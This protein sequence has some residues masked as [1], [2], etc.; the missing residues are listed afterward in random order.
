[1]NHQDENHLSNPAAGVSRGSF[2]RRSTLSA[3]AIL[4]LS[5]GIGLATAE[6]TEI[7]EKDCSYSY[8]VEPITIYKDYPGSGEYYKIVKCYCVNGHLQGKFWIASEHSI[9]AVNA[10]RTGQQHTPGGHSLSCTHPL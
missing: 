9:H 1:M 2:I 6:D 8:L 5:K 7:C 10:P 3:A 4:A